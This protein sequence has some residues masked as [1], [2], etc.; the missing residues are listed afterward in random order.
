MEQD[1]I[2]ANADKKEVPYASKIWLMNWCGPARAK[3][4]PGTTSLFRA[5]LTGG[6]FFQSLCINCHREKT[7]Q[8]SERTG[9]PVGP[10]ID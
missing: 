7:T 1:N 8:G 10:V 2:D 9:R 4:L 6:H 3:Q 5:A